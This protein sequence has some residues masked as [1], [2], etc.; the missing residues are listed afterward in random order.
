MR[1]KFQPGDEI[2]LDSDDPKKRRFKVLRV[3]ESS[4]KLNP[5][6]YG[7]LENIIS[8]Y[9]IDGPYYRHVLFCFKLYKSKNGANHP[10]TKIFV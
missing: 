2:Y 9:D 1:T 8:I 5:D 6:G 7:D 3:Y 4:N 10:L